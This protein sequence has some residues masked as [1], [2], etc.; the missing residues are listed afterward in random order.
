MNE[1]SKMN[2]YYIR[3]LVRE[4]L[5]KIYSEAKSESVYSRTQTLIHSA[6]SS[7]LSNYQNPVQ[8]LKHSAPATPKV[9][10][11]GR[12]HPHRIKSNI[13]KRDH[14]PKRNWEKEKTDEV[15]LF[16]EDDLK[17]GP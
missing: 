4:E 9:D 2:E 16:D 10:S 13:S 11:R 1:N 14:N 6:A 3:R 17:E 7:V 8:S 15:A 12:F 5:N